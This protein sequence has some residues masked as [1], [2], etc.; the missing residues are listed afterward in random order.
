MKHTEVVNKAAGAPSALNDGLDAARYRWIR[1][2][3]HNHKMKLP[4]MLY[5]DDGDNESY[6]EPTPEN[7]DAAIDAAMAAND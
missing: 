2:N 7:I 3:L 6:G 5:L 1:D 4:P